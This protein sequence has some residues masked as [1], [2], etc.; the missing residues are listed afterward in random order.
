MRME[1]LNVYVA[2]PVWRKRQ[3]TSP[4][5]VALYGQIEMNAAIYGVTVQIPREEEYLA[6]LGPQ[7]FAS[8]IASRVSRAN[9]VI[10]VLLSPASA[11]DFGNVS[12]GVEAVLAAQAGKPLVILA[13]NPDRV[14]RL[15]RALAGKRQPYAFENIDFKQ[16]FLSFTSSAHYGEEAGAVG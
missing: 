8:A 6:T 12:V 2:G 4:L 9:A 1:N 11:E 3:G 15:L 10:V 7:P 5:L 13:Q 16:L 14:P